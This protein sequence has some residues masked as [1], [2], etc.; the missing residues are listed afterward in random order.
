MRENKTKA[1]IL[2]FVFFIVAL[3]TLPHYNI[4]WDAINHL[5]R[6]QSYLRYLLIGKK[7][8]S[9]L[10][11]FKKYW[12]K[13]ESLFVNSDISKKEISFRSIYQYDDYDFNY[14]LRMDGDGHPP[15]SD[16][17]SSFFNLVFFQKLKLINDIDSYRLY[18]IFLASMLVGL[19]YWWSSKVYGK[20][21]GVVSALSLSLYP[22]FWAHSHFNTEKDIPEM[23]FYSFFIFFIWRFLIDK[24]KKEKKWIIWAGIFFGLALGTKL[25]IV[26]SLFIIFPW[27]L[28]HI[29]NNFKR[30]TSLITVPIIGGIIF[31]VGWPFL[32][33]DPVGGVIKM[34]KFYRG[35]GFTQNVSN[36]LPA[37]GL[38]SFAVQSVV[39][40]TPLVILFFFIIG[41]IAAIIR[42]KKERDK[43]SLLF[44]LWV[45]VPIV[46]VSLHGTNIYGG[47][48]QIMEYIPAM[49]ILA[50]LGAAK[51]RRF[52][53]SIVILLLFVP[54]L[55][56]LIQIHPYEEFYYNSLIGGLSGAKANNFP[57]WGESYGSPYRKAVEWIN[58]NAEKDSK[59]VFN[60]E[61][62]PNIPSIFFRQDLHFSNVFRSGYLREGEYAITLISQG[63]ATR[64]YYDMYLD[65]FLKPVYQIDI[66]GVPII[67]IWKNDDTHLIVPWN[68]DSITKYK[69]T[70]DKSGLLIDLRQARELSRLEINYKDKDCQPLESGY[71]QISEDN[72]SWQRLPGNLP[73]D[74]RISISG[75][76]PKNGVFI[77]PFVGQKARFI[78]LVLS[79]QNT[80]L[81]QIVDLKIFFLENDILY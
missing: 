52:L 66:D 28:F 63:I 9:G 77:E 48:R 15:I 59:V 7:D 6:G 21:A 40:I 62:M 46:R 72:K 11:P 32:W 57:Y 34:L 76:Q 12:Q 70:I 75:A 80:C 13:P 64:S 4:N 37:N 1:V 73:D 53:P 49:A 61:L 22:L 44:L 39:Y 79:P 18:G 71:V 51:L 47:V 54:I 20:F 55:V 43:T 36:L 38:N 8:Y 3:V 42:L 16:I 67:K 74:W 60:Y 81:K 5:P 35:L 78:S 27:L 58:K 45:M 68:E 14:F 69:L 29:R 50:G 23:V 31:F 30:I 33:Q 41:L 2:G 56:K 10:P 25:N 17:L 26:F 24:E 19:V 65:K